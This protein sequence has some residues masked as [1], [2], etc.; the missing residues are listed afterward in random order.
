MRL[1]TL[2]LGLLFLTLAPARAEPSP[3]DRTSFQQIIAA[4]M[5]AFR[6]DDG[7]AAFGFAS[8]GL[9]AKFGSAATFMEMV[10]EGYAPVYRPRAVEFRAVVDHNGQPEQQVFVIGPDGR[11][12]IAHYM[13][14]RQ[15]DGSWRISGC[16]LEPAQDES[17]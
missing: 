3:T 8:P 15:P 10:K 14:E 16:Y 2:A 4:Q 1:V 13:M 9:Q 7:V 12:Y 11:G 17:V 5:S 6:V